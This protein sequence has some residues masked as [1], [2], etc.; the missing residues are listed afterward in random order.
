MKVLVIEDAKR[1]GAEQKVS[2]AF[3]V[4]SQKEEWKLVIDP[5]GNVLSKIRD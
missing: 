4:K 1:I 3:E 5:Q 2:Y